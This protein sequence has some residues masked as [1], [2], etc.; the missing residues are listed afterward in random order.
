MKKEEAL[1]LLDEIDAI[2]RKPVK[3]QGTADWAFRMACAVVAKAAGYKCRTD[4]TSDLA[5]DSTTRY[6]E[7]IR[8]TRNKTR[9]WLEIDC[10]KCPEQCMCDKVKYDC[11]LEKPPIKNSVFVLKNPVA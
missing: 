8:E 7:Y 11:P 9:N 3:E 10:T 2:R 6:T 1:K 4:W 5:L